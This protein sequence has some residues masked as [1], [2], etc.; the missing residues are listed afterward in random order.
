MGKWEEGG[1]V[2][3]ET[4]D[5]H[6]EAFRIELEDGTTI[7]FGALPREDATYEDYLMKTKEILLQILATYQP[8]Q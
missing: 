6:S 4:L 2:Y 1:Y 5:R 3:G 7:N 8:S